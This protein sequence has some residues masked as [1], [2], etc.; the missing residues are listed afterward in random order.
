MGPQYS[1]SSGI[2]LIILGIPLLFAFANRTGAA[3]AFGVGKHK[4]TAQW[5]IVE[6]V[7]N[8]ILSVVLVHWYGIY[9]VAFGT[10]IPN[11]VAQVIFWPGYVYKLVGL[12]RVEVVWKVWAPM[13]LCGIPFAIATYAVDVLY[14]ARNLTIF[15]LQVIATL[16]VFVIT[17]GLV[18]RSYVRSQVLP[19]FRSLLFAEARV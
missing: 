11:L 13:F 12:S 9:G 10:M 19:R 8:L 6:G 17:I 7:A 14:P 5:A 3:I 16:A 1:H 18:F 15:F 2:V 4:A